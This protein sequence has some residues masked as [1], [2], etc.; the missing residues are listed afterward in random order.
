MSQQQT[1][2]RTERPTAKRVKDA[3]ERGQ[4]ARSRDLAAAASLAGATLMLGWSGS[5]TVAAVSD[6]M[7]EGVE[8]MAGA[9][10]GTVEPTFL[11]SLIWADGWL[12][13][14]VA[15]PPILAAAMLSVSGSLLQTGWAY[16]PKAL[17]ANWGR[18]N[19]ASGIQRFSPKQALPEL[20]KAVVGM[21][22][23][24]ALA[25]YLLKPLFDAATGLAGMHPVAAARH[26]WEG[27]WTLLWRTSL[28]LLVLAGGDYAIQ[29]WQWFTGLKM[30]RQE[31]RDEARM[32]DGSPELRARVR[33]VQR[34]MSRRRMLHNV[35]TATV[36]I[37][38]P[39]HF[40]VALEYRRHEMAAP[41]VVAKGQD[42]LA[43][44]IRAIAEKH[45]VPVV[46]NVALARALFRGVE[47]GETIPAG[48]FSAVAE[49]LAYLVRLKQL[50]L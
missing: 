39:T 35:K 16:S 2:E 10:R 7:R 17:H 38:N 46:E 24:G 31:V 44:K 9:A 11:T 41:V 49:V 1:G 12:L 29:R 8:S 42:L 13:A 33:R 5:R 34:D 36:V 40:A 25:Y 18:L 43:A 50:V 27:L 4:I 22:A 30:T 6:R 47:V 15:G 26:G 21:I 45:Q 37:T 14:L 32:N 23:V 19:P 3:R 20:G 48:L 28:L